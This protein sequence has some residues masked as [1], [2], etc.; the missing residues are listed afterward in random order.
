MKKSQVA[1]TLYTLRDHCK[2]AEDFT[3]TVARVK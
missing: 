3:Q 1:I 2:T